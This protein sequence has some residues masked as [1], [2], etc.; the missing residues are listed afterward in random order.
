MQKHIASGCSKCNTTSANVAE[1]PLA[2]QAGERASLPR[3]TWSAWPRASLRRRQR[4]GAAGFAF[5]SIPILQPAMAGVRGTIAARQFLFETDELYIDL[6]L[7]PH[8]EAARMCLV[9][10]ILNRTTASRT[11]QSL[12]VRLLKGKLAIADTATNQF[13]E[14]QLEFEPG[15]RC[16]YFNR[17]DAEQPNYPPPLW[18]SRECLDH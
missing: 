6:R 9:G 15:C 13:G 3:L 10:Q 18:A 16:G 7:E 14:F 2:R 4:S 11:A 1:R 8:R 17:S 12:L 5:S